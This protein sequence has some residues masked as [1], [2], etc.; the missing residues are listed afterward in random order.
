MAGQWRR[1]TKWRLGFRR[2]KEKTK[3]KHELPAI[4]EQTSTQTQQSKLLNERARLKR[5]AGTR[6]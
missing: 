2:E 5:V 3:L 6:V 1:K 4:I